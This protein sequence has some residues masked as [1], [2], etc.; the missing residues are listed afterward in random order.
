MNDWED[1][2]ISYHPLSQYQL[3]SDWQM[4]DMQIGKTKGDLA[5][6]PVPV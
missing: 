6:R 3:N 5:Q 4:A 2:T 1:Y